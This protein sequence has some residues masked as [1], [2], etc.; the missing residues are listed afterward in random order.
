M[1][2]FR[3]RLD[4]SGSAHDDLELIGRL[5]G[6]FFSSVDRGPEGV[7]IPSL[8]DVQIQETIVGADKVLDHVFEFLGSGPVE[9][10]SK[11]NWH[12]DFKSGKVWPKKSKEMLVLVDLND[13]S[14]V[15]V[16][17]ELSRFQH[18]TLLGRAYAFTNDEK[19]A[20]EFVDEI[21]DWLVENP[22]GVGVNWGCTMDVAIRAAN[23]I[24][25]YYFFRDCRS[26]EPEFWLK[27]FHSLYVH[28]RFI[29]ANLELGAVRGN[30]YLSD[31]VGLVYLGVLF[32]KTR[33]GGRWLSFAAAELEKE[34]DHQIYPDG[35]DHEASTSYQRLVAELFLSAAI[36][37]ERNGIKLSQGFHVRME[38]MLDFVQ[39]YTKPNGDIPLFGDADDGRLQILSE[40]TRENINDHRYLLAIGAVLFERV[41]FKRSADKFGEEAWWL[42]GAPGQRKYDTL[43]TSDQGI[44]SLS[45][46]DGG[47]Y[48]MRKDGLYMAIDCGPVGLRGGGGHGH[49]DALSIEVCVGGR[50]FITD[51]GSYVYSADPDARNR[52][53]STQAHNVI[54]MDGVE[55]AELGEGPALWTI[56]DQAKAKCLK[57]ETHPTHDLF[58]GE[59]YGYHGLPGSPI[60]HRTIYF[61]KEDG[62]WVIRDLASGGGIHQAVLRFHFCPGEVALDEKTMAVTGS[63]SE[64]SLILIPMVTEGVAARLVDSWFSPSYGVK[65]PVKVVEYKREGSIPLEFVTV[66][67]PTSS[68]NYDANRISCCVEKAKKHFGASRSGW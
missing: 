54:E 18:L 40:E 33:A 45:F 48:F 21:E 42:L 3:R 68:E 65:Y 63:A 30:H 64:G 38:L 66:I 56:A 35:V 39:A 15:K 58:V 7:C 28:G 57:W 43:P 55:M 4:L 60:V 49:N 36:L 61:D 51:S 12:Q 41:D 13:D 11:I 1:K 37:L 31:V 50:T 32:K 24:W 14:D 9:L 10:G 2:S 27:Y 20:S 22:C 26:I 62:L 34:M 25:A 19:Y 44:G 53:R 67:V 8:S 29:R 52:F 17:W 59:H 47:F 23:W 5:S 6:A 16:P 46:Q